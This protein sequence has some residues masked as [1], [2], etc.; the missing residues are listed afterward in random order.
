M[1]RKQKQNQ[2]A[3]ISNKQNRHKQ[4]N[5]QKQQRTKNAQQKQTNKNRNKNKQNN[6]TQANIW[7]TIEHNIKL[8]SA[9]DN[10]PT[11][12]KTRQTQTNKAP[13]NKHNQI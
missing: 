8:T 5:K 6:G 9:S 11:P 3:T 1:K 12:N 2:S 10:N 4:A 13:P 7:K